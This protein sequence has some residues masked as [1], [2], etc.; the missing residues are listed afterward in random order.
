ME[1][2]DLLNTLGGFFEPILKD[3]VAMGESVRAF[4][5]KLVQGLAVLIVLNIVARFLRLIIGVVCSKARLDVLSD[6][7]GLSDTIR[8]IGVTAPLSRTIASVVY[9]MVTLYAFKAA[10]DVWGVKDISNFINATILFLPRLFVAVFILFAG[11]LAADLA[12]KAVQNGFDR[13]KIDYG[14]VVGTSLYGLLAVMILT[15]VLGQLGIQTELLN[16]AV[17]ILLGSIALAV[18]LSLGLGLQ[19]VAKN[20][21]SGVYARD[22]F[23]PG[24]ILSIDDRYAV[25]REVGAVA[26]RLE[27]EA[28]NY[29]VI[30]NS[31]L[32]TEIR[33][34]RRRVTNM[35]EK[36]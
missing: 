8:K 12:R 28:G 16:A 18:A 27:D 20:I 14:Q 11:L 29:I 7:V 10:A 15:V 13:M 6:K 9:W 17:K 3:F 1:M 19:P 5:P 25:V 34:G 36:M 24:S 4:L 2:S 33:K 23:P 32:V 22:L 26:A 35:A 21:V 30:P 31:A